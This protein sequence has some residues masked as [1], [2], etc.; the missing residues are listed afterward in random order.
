[1][2]D[3][4]GQSGRCICRLTATRFSR[5]ARAVDEVDSRLLGYVGALAA[6]VMAQAVVSAV[7]Q[8]ETIEGYPAHRD[9][10]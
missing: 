1:M 3:W 4:R 9:L 7:L 6:D 5:S 8:A 10:G 2:T